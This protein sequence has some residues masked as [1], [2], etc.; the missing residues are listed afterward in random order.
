[1]FSHSYLLSDFDS[2]FK[3]IVGNRKDSGVISIYW[4]LGWDS[5]SH[6]ILLVVLGSTFIIVLLYRPKKVIE[7]NI[8]VHL[9]TT[10]AYFRLHMHDIFQLNYLYFRSS[11][12]QELFCWID[13]KEY[14][15]LHAFFLQFIWLSYWLHDFL[16]IKARHQFHTSNTTK[17]LKTFTQPLAFVSQVPHF[18]GT[19][20]WLYL[21]YMN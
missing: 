6:C 12:I 7:V 9:N 3:A 17:D 8:G 20:S 15:K 21:T 16:K 1:M 18:I 10:K 19:T 4:I 13:W 5:V 2:V 14:I 11:N